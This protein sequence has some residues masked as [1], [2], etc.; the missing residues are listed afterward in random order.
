MDRDVGLMGSLETKERAIKGMKEGRK[1]RELSNKLRLAIQK[2]NI[3]LNWFIINV[4][5]FS[6][7][8]SILEY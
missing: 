6:F 7:Q 2:L 8:I 3:K 5:N 1:E 4:H